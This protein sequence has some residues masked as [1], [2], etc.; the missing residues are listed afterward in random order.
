M[1][2]DTPGTDRPEE[3]DAG[4]PTAADGEQAD[5]G[6][7]GLATRDDG[8]EDAPHRR[9]RRRRGRW[10]LLAAGVVVLLVA[11]VA[12][13]GLVAQSR[14]Q[15]RLS[16]ITDPFAGIEDRPTTEEPAGPSGP[17]DILVLGSDSRISAGDPDQWEFGAQRTD[18]IMLVHIPADRGSMQIMSIPRD[19]WVD[20]P[21]WGM[22]KI[23]AAFS[24]GGPS[25]M[26]QT[27]EQLTGV[28]ID[29]FVVADFESFAELTDELGG[30]EITLTEPMNTRGV[31]L[32]AGP[33]RMT[34]EQALVYVRERYSLPRGD[35]DRVQR[36]QNWLR[37]I[38]R[39]AFDRD[40]LTN[41]VRLTSFLE[42]AAGAVAVDEGFSVSDMRGLALSM[43]DI[44]P[45]D[46]SFVT[47]PISGTGTSDDGQ[48]IVL[49]D[50]EPFDDLM[51]VVAA[52]DDVS[53]YLADD[54]DVDRLGSEVR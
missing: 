35:F 3:P 20:V 25:L 43:R 34:G 28:R 11:G 46:V 16:Y 51:A 40:V 53:A 15:S 33:Q 30:V 23:N 22:Y 10:A 18:A 9:A 8:V 38:M 13:A 32:D 17:L 29:H 21:G 37:A 12:I 1:S 36:Q 27:V 47:V 50:Q 45:G 6:A 24:F 54:E 42:T 41:P 44:R 19:S 31:D 39:S 48:S 7:A 14:I 52:D 2:D 26:I 5:Q 4:T 49:L